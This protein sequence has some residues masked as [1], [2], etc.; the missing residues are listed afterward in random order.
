LLYAD[1]EFGRSLNFPPTLDAYSDERIRALVMQSC[2]IASG[3]D[4][5][6]GWGIGI[7]EWFESGDWESE[8]FDLD[9]SIAGAAMIMACEADSLRLGIA[10]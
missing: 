2:V 1:T 8:N 5:D 6:I 3:A 4:S 10:G 9:A 7:A